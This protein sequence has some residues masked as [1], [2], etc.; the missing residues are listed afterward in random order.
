VGRGV[1]P[2]VAEE[3]WRQI[4]SFAAYSYCKAHASTYGHI[5]YQAAYL[6]AHWPAEFLASVMANKAGFYDPRTYLEDARRFNVRI[7]APCVNRS[8][9]E[10][11]PE[12]D[13]DSGVGAIRPGLEFVKGLSRA[14]IRRILQQR[15]L[16]PFASLEDFVARVK[17]TRP[18]LENLI[19][20]GAFDAFGPTRPTLMMKIEGA[21]RRSKPA[22]AAAPAPNSLL[23][24]ALP[25]VAPVRVP[26]RPP[27]SLKERVLWEL[28]ILGFS[29]SGHPLDAW[30]GE[31]KRKPYTPSFD[32]KNHAGRRVTVV[33]WLVTTRRAVTRNHEYMKFMTLEDRHGVVEVVVFPD[34]YRR[35]G[36]GM[37]G[38]GCYRVT[39]TVKEQHGA[40]SLVAEE[41]EPLP[42]P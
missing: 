21:L 32:M 41:V 17:I 16:R 31:L 34:V 4:E 6:K 7:L 37:A 36:Q 11:R 30:D 2:E 12:M 26:E 20:C 15:T 35:C 29:H 40:V 19:L 8:D 18:E 3:I 23:G 14:A 33:G 13:G 10:C 24:S 9:I 22:S 28:R 1:R 42:L 25:C 39:G 5:S 38:A 27:Y